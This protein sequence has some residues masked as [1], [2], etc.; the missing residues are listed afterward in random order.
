MGFG[1]VINGVNF[2]RDFRASIINIVG[3][4]ATEYKEE[5]INTRADTID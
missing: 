2:M 4:R 3:G 5:L 1:E